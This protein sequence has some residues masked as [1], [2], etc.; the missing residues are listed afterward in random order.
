MWSIVEGGC[1][2]TSEVLSRCMGQRSSAR[3]ACTGLF[4]NEGGLVQKAAEAYGA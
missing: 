3:A 4:S 2:Q 1:A